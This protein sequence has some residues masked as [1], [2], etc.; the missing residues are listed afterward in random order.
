MIELSHVDRYFKDEASNTILALKDIN[1]T[2]PNHG[3]F[4]ITGKSGSGKSTLLNIIGLIDEPSNGLIKFNDQNIDNKNYSI[5]NLV[6]K[7]NI[8]FVFQD[9]NLINDFSVMDNLKIVGDNDETSLI[10]V[11]EKVDLLNKIHT[12]V[13]L[14]SGGERQRLA[15]ARA[16]VKSSS[17]LLLDEPTGNLDDE[18]SKIIYGLLKDIS[19][20]K[21]VIIVTHDLVSA[22]HYGDTIIELSNGLISNINVINPTEQSKVDK[23]IADDNVK[24]HQNFGLKYQLKYAFYLLFNHKLKL[25]FSS[26]MLFLTLLITLVYLNFL[27]IDHD[28]VLHHAIHTN[29]DQILPLITKQTNLHTNDTK[30]YVKGKRLFNLYHTNFDHSV[31]ASFN[32]LVEPII[33]RTG[34]VNK[35]DL[36]AYVIQEDA[37]DEFS[38]NTLEGLTLNSNEIILTDF[39]SYYYFGTVNSINQDIQFSPTN[40]FYNTANSTLKVVGVLETGLT[41][42]QMNS[43]IYNVDS[44]NNNYEKLVSQYAIG[45]IHEETLTNIATDGDY[46][47]INGGNVLL[48][49]ENTLVY[50]G[51]SI[52]YKRY[53]SEILS[54]GVEPTQTFDVIFSESFL[55]QYYN[56]DIL[57]AINQYFIYKNINDSPNAIS[58]QETFNMYDVTQQIKVVGITSNTS[59]DIF[60]TEEF[61]NL[62]AKESY[63]YMEGY[64]IVYPTMIDIDDLRAL[65]LNNSRIDFRYLEP[66]YTLK[67]LTQSAFMQ[68]MIWVGLIFLTLSTIS[69]LSYG[70]YNVTNKHKEISIMKS[71]GIETRKIMNTFLFQNGIHL[72]FIYIFTSFIG[73]VA[74]SQI[75]RIL[76]LKEVLNINYNMILMDWLAFIV[77][78]SLSVI[79]GLL[80]VLAAMIRINR[81]NIAGSIKMN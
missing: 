76:K 61:M 43:L 26:L 59:A 69:V 65:T 25:F 75:N 21:L 46:V 5:R 27:F 53:D 38:N 72:S 14:L 68:I 79:I 31:V 44:F 52:R 35:Y 29:Q 39:F 15:I 81:I 34:N 10:E 23:T 33:F 36:R 56:G 17:I 66:A 1:L 30:D 42:D 67:N 40:K 60:I 6:R 77:L 54:N 37:L 28:K 20:H 78:L 8:G 13:R 22:K 2:F 24:V 48:S 51:S 16:L 57:E 64:S 55:N 32:A 70:L 50:S 63:Y 73:V 4:F 62:I 49:N 11:L 18:N 19:V 45:Y 7:N 58:F 47:S 74:I 12:N 71:L 9:F 80:S 41:Q 3:M